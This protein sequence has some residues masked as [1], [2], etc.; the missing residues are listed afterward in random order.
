MERLPFPAAR[1]ARN[2]WLE[3]IYPRYAADGTSMPRACICS[4]V[5]TLVMT[6]VAA[7]TS[8]EEDSGRFSTG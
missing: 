7:V 2:L 6:L 3:E 1:I 4:L 5:Q 8:V